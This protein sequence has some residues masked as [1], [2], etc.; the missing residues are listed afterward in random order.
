M[1]I[2]NDKIVGK[3]APNIYID[4]TSVKSEIANK[5]LLDTLSEDILSIGNDNY[6]HMLIIISL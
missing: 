3:Y 6:K 1:D 2:L 4:N 5:E